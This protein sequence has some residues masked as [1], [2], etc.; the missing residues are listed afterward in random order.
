MAQVVLE[1]EGGQ[2]LQFILELAERLNIR[3]HTIL[4]QDVINEEERQNR[5]DIWADFKGVLKN[6]AGYEPSP[7]EWYE[8]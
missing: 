2:D 8:Q 6:S 5:I 1:V 7:S 3:Y 4:N